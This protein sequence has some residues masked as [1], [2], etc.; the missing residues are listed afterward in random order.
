MT[1]VNDG[2]QMTMVFY[3]VATTDQERK[4]IPEPTS[5]ALLVT[6]AIAT[7]ATSNRRRRRTPR[8]I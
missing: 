6:G 1:N 3:N 7:L 4:M 5:I 8:T 2:Q